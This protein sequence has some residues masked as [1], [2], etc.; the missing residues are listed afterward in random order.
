MKVIR[1]KSIVSTIKK[2]Y[3]EARRW[4]R[5]DWRRYYKIMIDTD[6]GSIWSDTFLDVNS[7]NEYHS[8]SITSLQY[9]PGYVPETEQAYIDDAIELLNAAGWVVED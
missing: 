6:D 9:V 4:C 5:G 3:A 1:K 2:E 7:W 8:D